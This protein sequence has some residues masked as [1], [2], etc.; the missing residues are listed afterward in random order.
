MPLQDILSEQL[1]SWNHI[2]QITLVRWVGTSNRFLWPL[3]S[4]GIHNRPIFIQP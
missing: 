3:I 4:L 1:T 2:R